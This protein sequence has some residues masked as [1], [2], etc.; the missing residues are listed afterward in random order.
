MTPEKRS[1]KNI[2]ADADDAPELTDA[3]FQTADIYQGTT[4]V[5]RGRPPAEATKIS[6]TVRFSP[7]VIDYFRSG[8][9]GWQTRIDQALKQFIA[10]HP[11][12]I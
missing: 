3:F 8:G 5:R 4:L 6:T 10:E 11:Q 12:R 1:T 7:E 2:R 9:P